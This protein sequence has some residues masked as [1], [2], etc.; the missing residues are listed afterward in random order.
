MSAY[1]L[2]IVNI[3]GTDIDERKIKQMNESCF[4]YSALMDAVNIFGEAHP[5]ADIGYI[6]TSI[7]G[8][9]IPRITVGDPTA[10]K[11]I[12]YVGAHHGMEWITSALLMR[13]AE[14][15]ITAVERDRRMYNINMKYLFRTRCIHIIPMLNPDG[16]ELAIHGAT[17]DNPL[18]NRLLGQN[19]GSDDFSRWQANARGVDLNHNYNAGFAEYKQLEAE[20]NIYAG[21]TKYSGEHPESE[22]ETA[23]LAKLIRFSE[24][25]RLV[26]SLH[27]QGEEIYASSGGV[28]PVKSRSVG[29]MLARMCGY[30]LAE[31]EGTAAYGGLTDWLIRETDIMPF[32]FECGRG[33]NP[34]PYSDA[35]AIYSRIR[36]AL[37]TAPILI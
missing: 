11:H 33:E 14:E 25:L 7:L 23:A 16:V 5:S 20:M 30:T 32:T 24:R 8:R 9:G 31:P 34:L 22:P 37:F 26:I 1:Y 13:Y 3:H 15:Y 6:G 18:K 4:D 19:G 21:A 36:E 12:M 29:R 35:S 10:D 17:N 2:R 28:Y 27:T